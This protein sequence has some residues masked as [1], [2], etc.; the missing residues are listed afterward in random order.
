MVD[1]NKDPKDPPKEPPKDP[2][3]EP[4]KEPPKTPQDPPHTNS[5]IDEANK[6][7]KARLEIIE[8]EEKLQ[9]RK[10]KLHAEQLISGTAV[11]QTDGK[12]EETDK[13]YSDRLLRNE[14]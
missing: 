3:A 10:E 7:N 11:N 9:T 12:K 6:V 4:P 5:L 1:D 2:P 13:E 14:L 8:R